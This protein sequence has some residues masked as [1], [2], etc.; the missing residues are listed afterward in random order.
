M[1]PYDIYLLWYASNHYNNSTDVLAID[2]FFRGWL[3]D[4]VTDKEHLRLVWSS[5]GIISVNWI[6]K[7]A[8]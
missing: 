6:S 8:L 7:A 2:N 3:K 1:K 5:K 4:Q